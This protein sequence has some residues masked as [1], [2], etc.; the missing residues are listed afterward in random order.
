MKNFTKK[1]N[2]MVL[3]MVLSCCV[4]T[5][6]LIAQTCN[7]YGNAPGLATMDNALVTDMVAVPAT[8]EIVSDVNVSVD[9]THTWSADLEVTLTSPA[10]TT[11][12]LVY[13]ACGADDDIVATFDDAAAGLPPSSGGTCPATNGPYQPESNLG[14]VAG[15]NTAPGVQGLSSFNGEDPSGMWTLNV[16][17]DG[18][19]DGGTVNSWSVEVCTVPN[20]NDPC[21]AEYDPAATGNTA[22][23]TPITDITAPSAVCQDIMLSI[24][25][26][27]GNV[28]ITA[29]QIDNGSTD[30]CGSIASMSLDIMDFTCDNEGSNTVTLTVTD[31]AG[32]SATCT[33]TVTV[34]CGDTPPVGCP[35]KSADAGS[36]GGN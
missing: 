22:C 13:D 25:A 8:T 26:T 29:A 32:N 23:A 27:I 31:D 18:G 21:F 30:D 14:T 34:S 35:P 4:F 2:W 36:L 19:G 28:S 5:T 11:V 33:A 10:G 7:D 12:A 15:A 3:T 9:I 16:Y 17:D 24:D 1:I 20:C 6:Q